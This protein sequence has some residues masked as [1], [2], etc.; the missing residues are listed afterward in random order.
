VPLDPQR[1]KSIFLAALDRV[2][3]QRVAFL[4]EACA[5]DPDLRQRMERLLMAHDRPDSLPE[6]A[7]ELGPTQ[8]PSPSDGD[9]LAPDAVCQTEGAGTLIGPYK[10]IEQIGEGGM[11]TV[12]MAQQIEPVK[13]LVAVKLIKAGMDSKQVIARF[14]AERQALALMDHSNIARVLDAGT[15]SAGRPY[16][17]MDLVKGGPITRYCDEHR[18]TPRQRLELF[19]P[20]CQAVQHAHQ[21]GIIHRDLKPSNVLVALYDGKPVPKVIDFGVAKAAGQSLTDKTLVTGFGAIVGTFEYMSPEQ[22]EVNQL[23]IDTRSDIYS[24][25]V[26]LYELLVGSPPFSRKELQKAG[27][28]E[29]L[30]VIRE[31]EPSKP[32]TKLSSSDTLPTL[33]ANRGT[34]PAKLKK[35]VRGELDWIVMKALEKDRN[36]RYETANAFAMDVRRYL[37]DEPVQ[38]FPP[39]AWYR[40]GKFARK[41][42]AALTIA[43]VVVA[44][45]VLGVI[46]LA[47][48]DFRVKAEE[49]AKL[50]ALREKLQAESERAVE[51]QRRA[52]AESERATEQEKRANAEKIKAD[53]LE[54]WRQTAY[55]F[56]AALSLGEYQ[57]NNVA[58]ANEMLDKC[59]PELRRWEWHYLKHLCHSELSRVSVATPDQRGPM[60]LSADGTR[61]AFF[62]PRE[63]VV[64]PEGA[65]RLLT[66][67]VG[68]QALAP[69]SAPLGPLAQLV[70]PLGTAP[71]RSVAG[72]RHVY[73]ISTGK[74]V[75]R[76]L[77]RRFGQTDMTF[78]PDGKWFATCGNEFGLGTSVRVW[79]ALTGEEAAVLRGSDR[80]PNSQPPPGIY[81]GTRLLLMQSRIAARSLAPAGG[82]MAL[83]MQAALDDLILRLNELYRAPGDMRGVEFS[84]DGQ[85]VA[86]TDTRGHLQVWETVTSKTLFRRKA[87]SLPNVGG[88]TMTRPAFSADGKTVAT[89]CE[90]DGTFKL[91]DARTGDFV[92][93]LWQGPLDKGEGFSRAAFSP[94]GKWVAATGRNGIARG[95]DRSIL[96]PDSSV[97]VWNLKADRPQYVFRGTKPFT[98]LAF[99][100]DDNLLAAGSADNSVMI[101][102]LATGR[103][104]ATYRGDEEGVVAVAFTPDGKRVVST[105]QKGMIKTWDATRAPEMRV[106]R[107]G[108][109]AWHAVLSPDGRQ[110][111]AAS[112]AMSV[113]IWDTATGVAPMALEDKEGENYQQVAYSPDGNYLAAAI[114]CADA[115]G[116]VRIWDARTGRLVRTLPQQAAPLPIV[117]PGTNLWVGAPCL[118]LAYSPDGKRLASGGVDRMVRVWDTTTGKELFARGPHTGTVSGVAFSTDG[119]RLVSA[120]GGISW[121]VGLRRN[122]LKLHGDDPNF[123]PNLKVWDTEGKELLTLSLPRKTMALAISP[124]GKIIAVGFAD[125]TVRLYDAATGNEKRVLS[126]HSS[127]IRG[128][129]FSPDG[130]RL[131]S[132]AFDQSVKLWDAETGEEVLTL[133]HGLDVIESVGFS[134]DGHKIVVASDEAVRVWD[135]VPLKK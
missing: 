74:E 91:W 34:E 77:V 93:S 125:N 17:V 37:N 116:G 89:V 29:M 73:D 60:I 76:F 67:C 104:I 9:E 122:P 135:A 72:V 16:F 11:G 69:G 52:D 130:K 49:G 112:L 115:L 45:L 54:R 15:T 59:E 118:S 84:P 85:L 133:A 19:L 47:I 134:R 102:E 70:M 96:E 7:A 82:G 12:W 97:R 99:S 40:I 79:N 4:D 51:Q 14:E 98:C 5:G 63:S 109:G 62:N 28:L 101:W 129:A 20:V 107:Q 30:R 43:A 3:E 25:G 132:G 113:L 10:L 121:N 26:L 50:L 105:S 18:L 126:G 53:A 22:A 120:S 36:R 35:L 24:L 127:G 64:L 111:A 31:D 124:D 78:S 8:D 95:P 48:D 42:K 86:A 83:P 71:F 61:A 6:P 41:Q 33:S 27:M 123:V 44:A 80:W 39:S 66:H 23:D 1:A 100:P 108:G 68:G 117:K 103:E 65:I 46:G 81:W 114:H 58:R 21:K 94:K 88:N 131:L 57:A 110:V 55:Y 87:H 32:S 38:A 119:R 13:R 92:R 2:A 128:L 90:D 75:L 106:F 56:Q